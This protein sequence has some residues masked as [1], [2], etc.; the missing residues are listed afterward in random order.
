MSHWAPFPQ[1]ERMECPNCGGG[2]MI[3]YFISGMQF[4]PLNRLGFDDGYFYAEVDWDNTTEDIT[5]AEHDET[6]CE[7]CSDKFDVVPD[8]WEDLETNGPL[9]WKADCVADT[10]PCKEK[11]HTWS[12]ATRMANGQPREV[13]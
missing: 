8:M 2:I 1:K 5:E 12:V 4:R 11:R 9:L 3:T 13:T 6:Y 7:S 10:L